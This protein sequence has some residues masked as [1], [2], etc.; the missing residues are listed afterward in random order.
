MVTVWIFQL[1]QLAFARRGL[2]V[3]QS[4]EYSGYPA[5][6]ELPA[7]MPPLSHSQD[8]LGQGWLRLKWAKGQFWSKIDEKVKVLRMGLP[9]VEIL[10]DLRRVFLT[11]LEAPNSILAKNLKIGRI[12]LNLPI[13]PYSPCLGSLGLLSL[14]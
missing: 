10:A 2:L 6:G 8:G 7:R 3:K 13:F 11:Y 1:P 4:W 12:L 5:A 9:I 14:S